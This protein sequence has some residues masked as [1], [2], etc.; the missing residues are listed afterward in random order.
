MLALPRY[1]I[2]LLI[3]VG[4]IATA[5]HAQESSDT[6]EEIVVFAQK[7][8]QSL[9]DVGKSITAF[10]ARQLREFRMRLS[11]DLANQTPGLQAA[12]FSGD[13]TVIA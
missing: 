5:S 3:G 4:L 7:R 6:I 2:P 1:F 9:L 12:S 8:E 11:E 10:D 13:P